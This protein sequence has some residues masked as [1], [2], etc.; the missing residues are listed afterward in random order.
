MIIIMILTNSFNPDHR[1]FK[2]ARFLVDQGHNVEILC[3]DRKREC[4][5]RASE[6][7]DGMQVRRFFPL[8][9]PGS[10]IRQAGAYLKFIR[11]IRKYLKTKEYDVLHCHDLDGALAGYI[12]GN[13]H[14]MS[15]SVFDMHEFYEG[16]DGNRRIRGLIRYLVRLMQN[17]SDYIIYVNDIQKSGISDSNLDK[18][19][20]LPNYPD[21]GIFRTIGKTPSGLLRIS[22]IGK[23]RQFN[24]LKLLLDACK[25]IPGVSVSIHGDG[26]HYARLAEITDHYPDAVITGRY[27]TEDSPELYRNADLIYAVYNNK[28][29]NWN[30]AYPVKFFESIIT[31]TPIIVGKHTLVADFVIAND[32][33]Y[34]VDPG[35]LNEIRELIMNIC[36]HRDELERK[37]AN[38]VKIRYD[39]TW[40]EVV[41]NLNKVY[42][43]EHIEVCGAE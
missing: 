17:R 1:V 18:L 35:N 23:V 32:I 37:R 41:A 24:E 13:R 5:D 27:A 8:A 42:G 16:Q 15:R 9:R 30:N 19:I 10:G 36:M 14:R 2:E 34:T 3:W 31:G 28:V 25:P 4:I 12:A 29:A 22:Y 6:T 21:S 39:F 20:Y 38:M 26:S 43:T 7:I 11:E 33:G 40:E